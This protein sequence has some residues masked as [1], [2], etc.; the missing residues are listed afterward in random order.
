M[1]EAEVT[2]GRLCPACANLARG[3]GSSRRGTGSSW[4]DDHGDHQ[5]G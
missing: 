5:T 4:S 3:T 2:A 1:E